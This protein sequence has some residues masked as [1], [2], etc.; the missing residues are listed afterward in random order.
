[1]RGGVPARCSRLSRRLRRLSFGDDGGRLDGGLAK[2]V[3]EAARGHP[4]LAES[5]FAFVLCGCLIRV[6]LPVDHFLPCDS[7]ADLDNELHFVNF[8][9]LMVGG[10][11]RCPGLPVEAD[12]ERLAISARNST[13][14]A[15]S[16]DCA[17]L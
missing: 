4:D 1:L 5:P 14:F 8:T 10:V 17:P 3:L 6:G 9:S 16:A 11:L 12:L 13:H 7:P 15:V 2:C